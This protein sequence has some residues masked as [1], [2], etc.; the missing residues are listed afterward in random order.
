MSHFGFF[1]LQFA[2]GNSPH[3]TC[4]SGDKQ[5]FLAGR[6]DPQLFQASGGQAERI[7]GKEQA[8]V[9]LR[10]CPVRRGTRKDRDAN[11]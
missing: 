2:F 7:R 8:S 6:E 1:L 10:D 9:G 11:Q 4:V 5:P 3:A